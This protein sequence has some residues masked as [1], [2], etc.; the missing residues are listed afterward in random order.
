MQIIEAGDMA[1]VVAQTLLS[2]EPKPGEAVDFAIDRYA[3][4][5][6]KRDIRNVWRCV[7]DNSYGTDLI[8][9]E[10]EP[11]LHLTSGLSVSLRLSSQYTRQ[12]GMGQGNIRESGGCPSTALS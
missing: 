11:V 4:Y 9:S 12:Q 10:P 6:F 1:L 8:H 7:I 2:T 5:V 3:T